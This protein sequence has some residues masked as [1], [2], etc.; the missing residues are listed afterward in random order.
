MKIGYANIFVSSIPEAI[1]FYRDVLGLKLDHADESHGYASF[2]AGAISFGVAQT[3]DTDLVGRHTG[4]G[5]IVDDINAT[6]ESLVE[7]GVEFEM[8]PTKQPWGGTLALFADPDGNVSYLDP[9]G[10]H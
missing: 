4:L 6:Y 3:D 9:G 1:S 7:R 8:P 2:N 5:F 10:P